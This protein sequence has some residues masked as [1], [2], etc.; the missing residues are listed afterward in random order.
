MAENRKACKL[1]RHPNLQFQPG[2]QDQ[3]ECST[4]EE[5]Q[6]GHS[7]RLPGRGCTIKCVE[8]CP[9]YFSQ[10]CNQIPN[11]KSF[12]AREVCYVLLSGFCA[13]VCSAQEGQKMAQELLEL[14]FQQVVNYPKLRSSGKAV[15]SSRLCFLR[16]MKGCILLD[17]TD[18]IEK[19]KGEKCHSINDHGT[20]DC[21][22]GKA[23]N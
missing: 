11:K 15:S 7:G 2:W 8:G 19:H 23:Q 1:V 18:G 6:V 9:S 5:L 20:T 17:D 21:S 4:S 12:K 10:P 22:H 13:H 14:E 3:D 16:S